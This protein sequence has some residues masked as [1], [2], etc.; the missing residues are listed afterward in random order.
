MTTHRAPPGNERPVDALDQDETTKY[1]NF[2]ELNSGFIVTPEFG[3]SMVQSML[4]TTAN[5]HPDRDPTSWALYGTN[6][7]IVSED[8]SFGTDENWTL[9]DSGPLDLPVDRFSFGDLIQVDNSES[10]VSYRLIFPTVRDTAAANS[11]QIADVYFYETSNGTGN[12]VLDIGDE[13]LAICVGCT[14]QESSSPGNET[15]DLAIDGAVETKYLNFGEENSGFIVTPQFGRSIVNG[16]QITTANDAQERDPAAWALYGTDDAIISSNHSTGDFENWTLIDSGSI[17]LPVDRLT[18]GDVVDVTN[19][20][21]FTSYRMVFTEVLDVAAANSMQ[22][23][24]FQFFG[25]AAGG[26]ITGDYNGNG[27][28]DAG[29]LDVLAQYAQDQNLAGDLNG[30]QA[31]DSN[32]RSMWIETLQKSWVGDSNFDGEFSS[33]DFVMVFTAGKYENGQAAGYAEGDWN[34]DMQ[35]SSSDFVAAFVAGGYENGP[36]AATS[37]VPEPGSAG[38]LLMGALALAKRRRR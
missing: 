29:D 31:V 35:F 1:L 15:V 28:L 30:D 21:A 6:E 13:I 22:I 19:D 4:L 10:Y 33:S 26:G 38:L 27:S 8:N 37:A 34:G 36:R 14:V 11:M 12:S 2:G 16:F 9:V 32:D 3:P 17:E 18:E 7:P 23:A 25:E 24:E 20:K 5:D